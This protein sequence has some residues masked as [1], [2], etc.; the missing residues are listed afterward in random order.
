MK[1]LITG[2]TGQDGPYLAKLLLS[3]GYEVYGGYRREA[4]GRFS[5]LEYLGI[6][7]HPCLHLV[8]VELTEYESVRQTI[9]DVRPLRIYNLAAQSH[10]GLSFSTPTSTMMSTGLGVTHVL[11]AVRRCYKRHED[12][13]VYQASTSELFGGVA[14]RTHTF[15]E[16]TP[17]HPRSPYACAKLYAYSMMRNYREAYDM[18]TCNGILFNHESPLRGPNF[19]TRK[20][21]L[22]AAEIVSKLR[23]NESFRPLEIGN[24]DA[25][26]DW[27]HAEDYVNAMHL[28]MEHNE[29]SDYVIATG[30]NHTIRELITLAFQSFG[31][32]GRWEGDG[33][34]AKYYVYVPGSSNRES[35]I[36]KVNPEFFRPSDCSDLTGDASKARME[37]GW[38]PKYDFE[39]LV[40]EMAHADYKRLVRE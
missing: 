28:M 29:P 30:V 38:R 12:V 4:T 22:K 33:I 2:I 37:L 15:T 23:R 7:K 14:G 19:V 20:V 40:E 18:F 1:A 24:I 10:V 32:E 11:E 36:A 5:N 21:T 17:F 8:P 35:L 6:L 13:R 27:G 39:K 16:D 3:K 26:R 31:Y 34:D 9:E 25:S